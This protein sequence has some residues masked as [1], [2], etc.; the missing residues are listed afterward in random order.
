MNYA[1]CVAAS[2]PSPILGGMICGGLHERI[3]VRR[4][5]TLTIDAT[6][7]KLDGTAA[8]LAGLSGDDIRWGI[9]R[10]KRGPRLA[11]LTIGDGIEVTSESDGQIRI[12]F[13]APLPPAD[14]DPFRPGNYWGE[15]EVSLSETEATQFYGPIRIEPS[16]FTED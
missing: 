1:L 11:T 3:C 4:N 13:R 15:C 6:I 5:S 16:I 9:A 10:S 2:C 12:Q 7:M 8:S 14:P